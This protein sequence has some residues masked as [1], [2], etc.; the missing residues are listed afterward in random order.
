MIFNKKGDLNKTLSK[1][2]I[3]YIINFYCHK[4]VT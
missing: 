4:G 2:C 3:D 1:F